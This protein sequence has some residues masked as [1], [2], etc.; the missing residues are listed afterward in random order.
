MSIWQ[1][2]LTDRS[3]W[4]LRMLVRAVPAEMRDSVLGDLD[5]EAP[6]GRTRFW[7]LVQVAR[8]SARFV[9]ARVK[10]AAVDS[11]VDSGAPWY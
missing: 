2:H 1:K 8:I 10:D 4:V 6:A 5:E 11:A 3:G 7:R 9:G